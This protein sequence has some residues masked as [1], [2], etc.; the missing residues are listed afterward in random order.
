MSNKMKFDEMVNLY[1]HLTIGPCAELYYKGEPL[2]LYP[3]GYVNPEHKG[4]REVF[5]T[6]DLEAPDIRSMLIPV[7]QF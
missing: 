6:C 5:D 4:H 7:H 1:D 3:E 2:N